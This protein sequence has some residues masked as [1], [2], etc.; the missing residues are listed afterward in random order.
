[1]FVSLLRVYKFLKDVT[2]CG[3]QHSTQ[4]IIEAKVKA[5][6][7]KEAG[8]RVGREQEN[9]G[10]RETGRGNTLSRK[11]QRFPMLDPQAT[12]S[13]TC[14]Q[15]GLACT[16]SHGHGQD[17]LGLAGPARLVCI[18]ALLWPSYSYSPA[19]AALTSG[20]I[21][22]SWHA[23]WTHCQPLRERAEPVSICSG[24]RPFRGGCESEASHSHVQS[25]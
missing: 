7:L 1:M 17:A 21:V 12:D 23:A 14:D 4:H 11:S 9:R 10:G 15:G 2:K 3:P 20:G 24:A 8:W 19:P 18:P 5:C 13:S 22:T 25:L 6:R 16:R